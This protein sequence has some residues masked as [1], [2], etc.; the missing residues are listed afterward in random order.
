MPKSSQITQEELAACRKQL[1]R[2]WKSRKVDESLLEQAWQVVDEIAELR[3]ERPPVISHET[4]ILLE[5]LLAFRHKVNNI[6]GDELIYENTERHAKHI[7]NLYQ[8]FSNDV[9][10]FI[11][12][13]AQHNEMD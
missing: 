10:M 13:L 1:E 12:S 5:V 4:F 3:P 6:Y 2:R 11:D 7:V 8:H 9:N